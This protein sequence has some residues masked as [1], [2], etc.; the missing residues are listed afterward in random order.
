MI[1]S[2]TTENFLLL[3]NQL[4]L[5]A[6]VRTQRLQAGPKGG[7]MTAQTLAEL[8]G[9]GRDTIFRIE[10]GE[11][12]SFTTAMRVLRV[13]GLGASVPAP[14]LARLSLSLA[15]LGFVLAALSG[16]TMFGTMPGELL[17]NRVFTAKMLLITLAGCNAAWFHG[18]GSLQ[19]LDG[20]ARA[21]M[22][23]ST[24]IWLLVLTCGRWIGYT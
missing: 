8:A 9:V 16:L 21:L 22:A 4:D 23:L 6:L 18:R 15:S 2:D 19:K 20:M 14:A 24:V 1:E 17:A 13:F 7:K 11:D 5:A 12:V 3:K 10:R